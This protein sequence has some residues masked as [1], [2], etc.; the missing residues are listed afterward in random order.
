MA[1][2]Q[3]VTQN[4]PCFCQP[5]CGLTG[6]IPVVA[7]CAQ[8]RQAPIS[9]GEELEEL[10]EVETEEKSETDEADNEKSQQQLEDVKDFDTEHGTLE[11]DELQHSVK[12]PKSGKKRQEASLERTRH[13]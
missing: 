5:V 9:E 1:S 12:K 11:D 4:P 13:K 6:R 8:V 10:N 3:G 2:G 7:Q